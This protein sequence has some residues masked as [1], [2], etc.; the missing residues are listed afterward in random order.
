MNHHNLD[1]WIAG[2]FGVTGGG[3]HLIVMNV[4]FSGLALTQACIT[5]FLCGACGVLGRHFIAWIV[6]E[7]KKEKQ[8]MQ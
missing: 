3:I 1:N 4:Q 5:A 2:I 6:K 8:K 7:M